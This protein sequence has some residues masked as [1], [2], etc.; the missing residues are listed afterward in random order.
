MI[1]KILDLTIISVGMIS[2][3]AFMVIV[4]RALFTGVVS[5]RTRYYRQE[6]FGK[7]LVMIL[8]YL[9]G[10]AGWIIFSINY[11]I[12]FFSKL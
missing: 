11:A 6:S 9:V 7:Y 4:I 12:K 8:V 10:G 1:N 3:I 5:G 2:G